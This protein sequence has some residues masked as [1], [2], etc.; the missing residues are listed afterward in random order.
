MKQVLDANHI[1]ILDGMYAVTYEGQIWSYRYNK[2][3]KPQK[4]KKGNYTKFRIEL[5]DKAGCTR[6]YYVGRLVAAAYFD[7]SYGDMTVEVHHKDLDQQNN[8]VPNLI[9]LSP[10]Q[11]HLIHDGIAPARLYGLLMTTATN[12]EFMEVLETLSRD[13]RVHY[14]C[15]ERAFPTKN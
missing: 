3:L 9:P 4:V 12:E 15:A 13:G 7:F 10:Y 2:Y 8:A 1:D 14:R 11:H 5:T 6:K